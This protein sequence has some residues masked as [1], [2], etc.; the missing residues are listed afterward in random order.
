MA[1][2]RPILTSAMPECFRYKSVTT[3]FD[4]E[5]FIRK[6]CWLLSLQNDTAY[7]EVMSA[8]AMANTWDSRVNDILKVIN[9]EENEKDS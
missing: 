1:M 3:Y 6:A 5:D 7:F 8:E 4:A 2:G 9:G